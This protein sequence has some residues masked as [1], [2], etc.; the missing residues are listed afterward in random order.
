M[1]RE[2]VGGTY[3]WVEQNVPRTE[4]GRHLG[5]ILEINTYEALVSIITID[6]MIIHMFHGR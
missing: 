2:V 4:H 5:G 3:R 6:H 1:I